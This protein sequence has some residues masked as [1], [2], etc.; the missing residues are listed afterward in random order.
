MKLIIS[1]VFILIS[2]KE[3][4]KNKV[5]AINETNTTTE[6]VAEQPEMRTQ[7]EVKV[8]YRASTR[9]FFLKTW[10][11][12][13]SITITK[14]YNLKEFS[15]YKI[16]QEEKEAFERLLN[17]VDETTLSELEIPSKTHQYDAAPAAFLEISKGEE[18]F[19]TNTFDHGKPPKTINELVEKL[20]YIKDMVEKQ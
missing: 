4:D 3:C 13:D 12:G 15:T 11:E 14:D 1:L 7:E 10:I 5:E 16:P 20:L 6:V 18:L 17:S 19:R 9:G 2:T 8:T